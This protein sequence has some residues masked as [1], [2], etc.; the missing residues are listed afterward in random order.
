[1]INELPT[2]NQRWAA[3]TDEAP[4]RNG[5]SK[6]L[7]FMEK[8]RA[9]FRIEKKINENQGGNEEY[10]SLR[11]WVHLPGEND[12]KAFLQAEAAGREE[13]EEERD[14]K[15]NI[16]K[17]LYRF[18]P[19]FK[20]CWKHPYL[21]FMPASTTPDKKHVTVHVEGAIGLVISE[22]CKWCPRINKEV[23]A[24]IRREENPWFVMPEFL[25]GIIRTTG[26]AIKRHGT[27]KKFSCSLAGGACCSIVQITD[28]E[29]MVVRIDGENP[30]P[31]CQRL[32][33]KPPPWLWEPEKRIRLAHVD[34]MQRPW[35]YKEG[36][37]T[38]GEKMKRTTHANRVRTEE[39]ARGKKR[40]REGRNRSGNVHA[41][42]PNEEE[43]EAEGEQEPADGTTST[44][45]DEEEEERGEE[46]EDVR[47]EE[48][49][50][51]DEEESSS[52][53]EGEDKWESAEESD[54]EMTDT[55]AEAH[56]RE[57]A[58][59]LEIM[60]H[61]GGEGEGHEEIEA[62]VMEEEEKNDEDG[63]LSE[64]DTNK[65]SERR[66]EE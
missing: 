42:I 66:V 45:E 37:E 36:K 34:D 20:S 13:G 58:E 26:A 21:R 35:E 7:T 27:C 22:R 56:G 6:D 63:E 10:V 28:L 29:D 41:R 16:L 3:T 55:S 47:M 38:Q 61:G 32:H 59:Q 57:A 14:F 48:Y 65:E 44:L 2:L 15:L 60:S 19:G 64:E 23:N 9:A 8:R 1:M 31:N 53:E 49:E 12:A 39:R 50:T 30:C 4:M 24:L 18:L 51:A 52:E 33:P 54:T 11:S 46:M 25:K 17:E 62:A 5:I 40:D 43:D